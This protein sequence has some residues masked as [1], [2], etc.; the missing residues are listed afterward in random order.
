MEFYDD[1]QFPVLVGFAA[2]SATRSRRFHQTFDGSI[3]VSAI[4][5]TVSYVILDQRCLLMCACMCAGIKCAVDACKK[6]L[7]SLL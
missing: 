5:F 2:V 6:N 3:R 7:L 1:S 4:C